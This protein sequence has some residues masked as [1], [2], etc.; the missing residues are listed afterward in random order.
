LI[1]ATGDVA[2]VVISMPTGD[3][4][5]VLELHILLSG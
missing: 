1:L 3:V 2:V 4:A 5:L